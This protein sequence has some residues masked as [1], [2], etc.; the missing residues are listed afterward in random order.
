MGKNIRYRGDSSGLNSNIKLQRKWG[1][2][3]IQHPPIFI[4]FSSKLSWISS[5]SNIIRQG[6]ISFTNAPKTSICVYSTP[7]FGIFRGGVVYIAPPLLS[8][9]KCKSFIYFAVALHGFVPHSCRSHPHLVLT[10]Q[11]AIN[12]HILHSFRVLANIQNLVLITLEM[13]VPTKLDFFH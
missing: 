6:G 5:R 11:G 2:C 13:T 1:C 4:H 8:F 10:V 9:D 7:C 12:H 3:M